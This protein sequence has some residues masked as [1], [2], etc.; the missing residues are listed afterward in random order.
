[1]GG[2]PNTFCPFETPISTIYLIGL[3]AFP[4]KMHTC[5]CHLVEENLASPIIDYW[6]DPFTTFELMDRLDS[7]WLMDQDYG[8][9][10][11]KEYL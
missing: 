1:M 6:L 10:V 3:A 2:L 7:S 9:I 8:C 4:M 5:T 11:A